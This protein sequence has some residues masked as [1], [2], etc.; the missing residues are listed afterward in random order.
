MGRRKKGYKSPE[1]LVRIAKSRFLYIKRTVLGKP[2]CKSTGT[3]DLIKA[4][5]IYHMVMTEFLKESRTHSV[6]RLQP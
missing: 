1:G 4:Q 2:V 6:N 5:E 3:A